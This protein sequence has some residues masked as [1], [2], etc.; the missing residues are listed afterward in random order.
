[1][2]KSTISNLLTYYLSLPYSGKNELQMDF[3]WGGL[4]DEFKFHLVKWSKICTR[5]KSG[6]LGVK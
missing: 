1:L 3:L 2:I 4:S 6:G 5:I